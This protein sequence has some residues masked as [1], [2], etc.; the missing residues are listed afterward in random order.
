MTVVA[1]LSALVL[2]FIYIPS[3]VSTTLQLRS[4]IIPFFKDKRNQAE[5]RMNMDQVTILLGSMFWGLL[6]SAALLGAIVGFIVFLFLWQVSQ[7][8]HIN[9]SCVPSSFLSTRATSHDNALLLSSL[10]VPGDS[11]P[12]G[13][14]FYP[15]CR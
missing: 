11:A 6:Y 9:A 13:Y 8:A 1:C 7:N 5:L 3:V 12:D 2:S 4:G 14:Y 15:T 10:I